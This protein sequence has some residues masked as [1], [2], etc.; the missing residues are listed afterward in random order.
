M[1]DRHVYELEGRVA[2]ERLRLWEGR[3]CNWEPKC[4]MQVWDSGL[5]WE[6]GPP[7]R[8]VSS[9]TGPRGDTLLVG[10]PPSPVGV[11]RDVSCCP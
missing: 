5:G 1:G 2:A 3:K 11:L 6:S 8:R 10:R 9:F 4:H 7:P